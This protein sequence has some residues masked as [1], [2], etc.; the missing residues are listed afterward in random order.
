MYD[1]EQKHWYDGLKSLYDSS[2][3]LFESTS[4]KIVAGGVTLEAMLGTSTAY[5]QGSETFG[6]TSLVND[7]PINA[8]FGGMILSGVLGIACKRLE[9]KKT[10]LFLLGTAVTLG[11]LT[12]YESFPKN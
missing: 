8:Y 10:A 12:L 7:W 2:R 11:L 3:D 5:A 9:R 1:S 6:P 4:T